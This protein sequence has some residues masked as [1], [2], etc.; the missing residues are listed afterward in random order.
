MPLLVFPKCCSEYA[1]L[2]LHMPT[3]G[4][5]NILSIFAYTQVSKV[6]PLCVPILW[7]LKMLLDDASIR[8]SKEG[9]L[10]LYV[11]TWVLKDNPLCMPILGSL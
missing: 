6:T 8:I 3:L 7:S 4:F 11:Y 1:S 9:P 10:Y 2:S 5:L